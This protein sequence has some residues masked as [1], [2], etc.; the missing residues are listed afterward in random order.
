MEWQVHLQAG[1][2]HLD[3]LPEHVPA[4][5]P[6]HRQAHEPHTLHRPS[7]QHQHLT[8]PLRQQVPHQ[9]VDHIE[10]GR[11]V[12]LCGDG[13]RGDGGDATLLCGPRWRRAE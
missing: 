6:P 12:R 1:H 3:R 4:R 7:T 10:E 5:L 13:H 8:R 9:A 2:G 11:E